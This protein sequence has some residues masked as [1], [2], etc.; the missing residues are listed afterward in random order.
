MNSPWPLTKDFKFHYLSPSIPYTANY[1]ACLRFPPLRVHNFTHS[2]K[3]YLKSIQIFQTRSSNLSSEKTLVETNGFYANTK[4]HL[5]G[6]SLGP[7]LYSASLIRI[8]INTEG[9]VRTP[10]SYTVHYRNKKSPGTGFNSM[11]NVNCR[12][13]LIVLVYISIVNN[14]R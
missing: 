10:V 4:V 3:I 13:H 14:L 8:Y 9:R 11:E 2:N 1:F 6:Q 7:W 12:L 5:H